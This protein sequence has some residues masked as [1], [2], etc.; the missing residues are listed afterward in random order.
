MET[1]VGLLAILLCV[2]VPLALAIAATVW[3][4]RKVLS[5]SAAPAPASSP[6]RAR[7]DE[8]DALLMR[9]VAQGRLASE[10]AAQVRTLIAEDRYPQ[11]QPKLSAEL[12]AADESRAAE[13]AQAVVPA[14]LQPAELPPIVAPAQPGLVAAEAPAIEPA[15]APTPA[16]P[17]AGPAAAPGV[18]VAPREPWGERMWDA[19]LSLR[20]R[21]TLLFL[22]AFLLVVS[23][24]VLVVFNWASFPPILQFALLAGVCGGLWA[25]GAWLARQSGLERAG[26]GLQA[27]GGVLVP[28]VA[29]S[30]SRPGLLDLQP[31]GAWLLASALSLP[32]YALAAWRLR[33][34]LF[35]VAGCLSA[36]SAVL[37]ALSGVDNQWLPCALSLTLTCYLPLA[38][39]LKTI[40]PELAAGPYWVAQ[41]G[42]P[43]ALLAAGLLRANGD[44][45]AGALAATAWAATAFYLLAAWLE[46]REVWSWAAALLL[47]AALFASLGPTEALPMH[48]LPLALVALAAGYLPLARWLRRLEPRLAQAPA[49]VAHALAPALLGVALPLSTFAQSYATASAATLWAGVLFYLLALWLDRRSIWAWAA[50]AVPPFALLVTLEALHAPQSW[51]GVAPALLALAYLGLGLALEPRARAYALPAYVGAAAVAALA[52][53]FALFAPATARWTLPLLIVGG[54]TVVL[55]Y[56]RGRFAWLVEEQ[57]LALATFGLAGVG[58]LLPG[59]LLALLQL[60][61]LSD[62]QQGLMLLPLAALYLA[63]AWS[64]PGRVRRT[65]DPAL[66]ALGVLLALG[67]GAVTLLER[68]TWVIGM[69]ALTA[70]WVFQTLL[71]RHELWA[72]AALGN[73]LLAV[74]LQLAKLDNDLTF[75]LMIA[76]GVALSAAYLLGGTLLRGGAWRCWTRPAIGWGALVVAGTLA[77][78]IGGIDDAAIVGWQHVVAL[79]ALAGLLAL[80]AALWRVAWPGFLVAGL[81]ASSTLLAATSGFFTTWRPAVGE[82]GYLICAI[83]LGLAVIGQALRRIHP[84]YAYPYEL[85]GFALL[86]LAPIPAAGSAQHAALTWAGM[87]LLY[88]LASWRYRL[89]WAAAPAMLAADIALLNGSAWLSVGGRPAGAG[90][91][92]LVATWAQALFGLWSSRRRQVAG[93]RDIMLASEPGYVVAVLSG[94]GALALASSAAD[95]LAI[96]AFGLAALLALLATVHRVELVAWAALAPLALGFASLHAYLEITALWSVAWGV[97]EALALCLIGW[98]FEQTK[99][100]RPKTKDF[101]GDDTLVLGPWSLVLRTWYRPLWLGP[102]LAGTTLAGVLLVAP[103]ARQELPPLTFALATLGLL[104]ATL[105]VRRRELLFAYAAGAALVG[106]ALCQLY[107]W[108]FRQPQWFTIPA[109][110]YLLALAEGLR[111]FQGQRKSSQAIEAGAAAVLLGVTF[112]Q[113]LR[114]EGLESQI[115]AAWLC[116]EALLLLGYGMLRQ[117]RVPF[118]GGAAFFVAG[119]LWLSVD[120][121]MAANK[122]VLLGALGLLMVGVYVLLERRQ[123]ELVRAGRAWVQ[124]VSSW[125]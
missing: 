92:L 96:V 99:D 39:R 13:T 71:R 15:P 11:A 42:L 65:Y 33:H 93:T 46:R 7:L 86:T 47:P 111:R 95:V 72:A 34:T 106:A 12:P 30:L 116:V 3:I 23:A 62:A 40:A 84:R 101:H 78:V 58:V 77:A 117:L 45:D 113:S 26:A 105:A 14:A 94:L 85:V 87:A 115:Y 4:V 2:V 56:H 79:L 97:A 124:R 90:L 98:S 81:L 57:R 18:P 118:F 104:L 17:P 112:G 114:A 123:E 109:G 100:Q 38:R 53:I 125:G 6:E 51:W 121:L 49:I 55:A 43:L 82:Y 122:W 119:V 68:E 74:G 1:L 75:D 102:L 31:R 21:Q 37:A 52:L 69:G 76:T 25:G 10:T 70:I 64:W 63:A 8:F 29:F 24:L 88:G 73:L 36:A 27:V 28:V 20:T 107:D 35:A 67:A 120:P 48:W 103:P 59:W 83:T 80:V 22:G 19:L 110:V 66:Q 5:P 44:M 61:T 91:L 89:R 9:W 41:A 108:G 60:S 50:L 16:I 54:A 32:I